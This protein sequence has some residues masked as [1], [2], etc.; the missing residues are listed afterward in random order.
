MQNLYELKER[1]TFK[2]SFIPV[3]SIDAGDNNE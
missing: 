2:Q 1:N 3:E